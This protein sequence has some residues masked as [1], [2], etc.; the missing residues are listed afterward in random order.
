MFFFSKQE[1]IL[2]LKKQCG[3]I[4]RMQKIENR[5][6]MYQLKSG[7]GRSRSVL[8]LPH[9]AFSKFICFIQKELKYTEYQARSLNR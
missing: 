8:M 7:I 4:L 2:Y 3:T 1:E 6:Q 9:V 5:E